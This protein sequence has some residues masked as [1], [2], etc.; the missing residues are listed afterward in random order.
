MSYGDG[1]FY[2]LAPVGRGATP[3]SEGYGYAE[4][5]PSAAAER[6][7]SWRTK[8]KGYDVVR[9]PKSIRSEGERT[10]WRNFFKAKRNYWQKML[11]QYN[12][13]LHI[14]KGDVKQ[15]TP[16]A[17]EA[18][19]KGAKARVAWYKSCL[20]F[21]TKYKI[22]AVRP[23]ND[24]AWLALSAAAKVKAE[25]AEAQQAA[26]AAAV[27]QVEADAALVAESKDIP[28]ASAEEAAAADPETPEAK[29]EDVAAAGTPA[30]TPAAAPMTADL[31]PEVKEVI[32]EQY[33][34]TVSTEP[35]PEAKA[36]ESF[37]DKYG[38]YIGGAVVLAGAAYFFRD[39]L[40]FGEKK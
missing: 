2:F 27:A 24:A 40:G 5:L 22:P 14:E 34:K 39:S 10:A 31:A 8:F 6:T 25:Q 18:K 19:R 37:F 30:I 11:A 7:K 4:A 21:V 32:S 36:E 20:E 38:M 16:S 35:A 28:E 9:R 13:P 15:N 26:Q 29:A 17:R 3:E 1:G 12:N 33:K 23:K